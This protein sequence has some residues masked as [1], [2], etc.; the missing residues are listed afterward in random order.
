MGNPNATDEEVIEA[1]KAARCDEFI[2][3]L[4]QGYDT[5]AGDAGGKLSGGER[6]VLR[7]PVRC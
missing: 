7:L 4:E 3:K 2:R 1:A 6:R 5:L